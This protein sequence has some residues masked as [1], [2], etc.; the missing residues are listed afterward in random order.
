MTAELRVDGL[1]HPGRTLVVGV[2]N[3]TPDSFSDGGEWLDPDD[4][5]VHGLELLA[6]GA[7]LVDVG[8]ESTRPG[9][10]RPTQEVELA[11]VIPVIQA[12]SAAGGIVSVDTMR[13][14]VAEQA[15]AAGARAINDV[16]GGQADPRMLATVARLEVPYV[17][18]HWRGHSADMQ[19]RAVYADLAAEVT[20]EL[21]KQIEQVLAAGIRRDR[22]IL[23]PGF[24]FAK[25]GEHN[26]ELLNHLDD[27]DALGYPILYGLSRK[28]FLGTLLATPDGRPRPARER[29]DASLALTTLLAQRRV[30]AVRVHRV[31][32]TCDAIAVVERMRRG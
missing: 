2:V 18:M 4:A 15:V 1:P 30:W 19:S 11:R 13:S 32:S 5:I 21:S 29:D 8:G 22:L 12:L 7:D 23:D 6:E 20:A 10:V 16:S 9:A 14:E 28:T 27:L 26:W 17:C 3:V 31:R 25:T 24:G